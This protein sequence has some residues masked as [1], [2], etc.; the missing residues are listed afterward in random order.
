MWNSSEIGWKN[1]F[2]I[3]KLIIFGGL[4]ENIR[5]CNIG[6][7]HV[8]IV[9]KNLSETYMYKLSWYY[10]VSKKW[11]SNTIYSKNFETFTNTSQNVKFDGKSGKSVSQYP[12]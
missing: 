11:G 8:G 2:S 7:V 5:F 9:K 3:L 6:I 10:D 4:R 1:M 12:G